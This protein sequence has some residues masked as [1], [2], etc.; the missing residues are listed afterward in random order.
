MNPFNCDW[1]LLSTG[2]AQHLTKLLNEKIKSVSG[3]HIRE[4]RID[5]LS[6][7]DAPPY[8]EL[9]ALED[10]LDFDVADA[11]ATEVDAETASPLA[12]YISEEGIFAKLRVSYG[13][14]AS[15]EISLTLA[16]EVN[17]AGCT[18]PVSLPIAA[19]VTDIGFDGYVC[20]NL[21]R[22]DCKLWLEP[23][24]AGASPLTSISVEVAVGVVGKG[25]E[26]NAPF[27]DQLYVTALLGRELNAALHHFLI[28]P[29]YIS[30]E[31]G[32]PKPQ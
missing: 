31:L 8:V 26:G 32:R 4:I 27:V 29:H 30:V 18:L 13:G 5:S 12:Y 17:C 2:T 7:G 14:S 10:A 24:K 15:G 9:V 20:L 3:P 1:R 11:H 28:A 23:Q 19:R 25:C 21:H 22:G 16:Q 6:F